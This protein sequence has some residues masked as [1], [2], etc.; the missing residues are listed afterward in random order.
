MTMTFG[1]IP[2]EETTTHPEPPGIRALAESLMHHHGLDG[3]TL[4]FDDA[5]TRAGECRPGKREISLSAPL[6]LL[7]TPEQC[8]DIIKHEIAHA[9]TPGDPGHGRQWQRMC[10]T[11]GA[12]PSRTWGHNGEQA[13][14]GK[15]LGTCPAGHTMRRHRLSEGARKM[16]CI[17]CNPRYD[18]RY[19]FTWTITP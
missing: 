18:P 17:R 19:R 5:Q 14:E 1:G 6:M 3:W 11:I 2:A 4:S 10:I 16:S 13:I 8:E 12:D 15:H 9:L 7:W